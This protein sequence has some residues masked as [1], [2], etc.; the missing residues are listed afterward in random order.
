VTPEG[1]ITPHDLG[2]YRDEHVDMLAKITRFIDL[3]G[4]VAGIQLAHAGRKAATPRPW[5]DAP[6]KV[7]PADGGWE[8]VAPSAIPFG[9]GSWTPRELTSAE[10]AD[11]VAAF[12]TAARRSL[13]AGFRVAEIHGAHGY[14]IHEFLSPLSNMRTDAYGGSFENRTRIAREVSRAVRA[15]WPE[16]LPLFFRVSAS[17]WAEGGWTIEESV[18]L[19]KLLKADGVDVVDASSGGAVPDAKIAVGPGYQVPFAERIRREA[20]IATAAVGMITTA[21]QAQA[22]LADG[23]ADLIFLAREFLRDPYWPL[24]AA[25]AL[26]VDLP[27]PVQYERAKPR[28]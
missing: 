18:E 1:R 7:P 20:G 14:L 8:P 5:D 4:A 9:P 11:V 6:P 13:E 23:K 27:W 28:G 15:V 25:R 12:A 2:I 26:G 16:G 10:I 17:D 24:H 19:A 3:Q 21:E 22:I